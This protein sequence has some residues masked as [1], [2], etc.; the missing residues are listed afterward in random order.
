MMKIVQRYSPKAV[1]DIT[2]SKLKGKKVAI[3]ANHFIYRSVKALRRGMGKTTTKI[4][5]RNGKI[6]EKDITHIYIMFIRLYGLL[7]KGIK[8]IFVFDYS[9]PKM[10][11]QC[12]VDRRKEKAWYKK[13]YLLT[14]DEKTKKKYY[15]FCSTITR[16]EYQDIIDL[17]KMFGIPYI[18]A[19]EEA[20][21]QCAYMSKKRMVDY[22]ISDDADLLMFGCK[23]IV[24]NFTLNEKKKM[25]VVDLNAILKQTGL[26]MMAFIHLGLLMGSDYTETIPGIGYVKAYELIKKHRSIKMAKHRKI[27]PKNYKYEPAYKYFAKSVHKKI[28]KSDMKIKPINVSGLRKFM[29]RNGFV[30]SKT[31]N[32]Y[33]DKLDGIYSD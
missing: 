9:Y 13:K 22:V 28:K 24:K 5:G 11:E 3:D 7:D 8:P 30:D 4:K 31:I 29:Y 14:K 6:Y 20:D 23:N 27:I 15:S 33:L 2:V 18:F 21:S 17:I 12:L 25:K 1:K 26:S 16:K 19:H 32:K 10:K